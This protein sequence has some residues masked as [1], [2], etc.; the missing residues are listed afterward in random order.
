MPVYQCYVPKGLLDHSVKAK[1]A[2]EITTIHTNATGAP[3]LYVNVLFHEIPDGDHFVARKPS[4]HS[5]LFGLIRHGRDLE[6][7]Q[8]MLRDFSRMWTR[9]TGQSEAELLVALSEADPANAMEAG[10]IL[11]EPGQE[12][13]WFGENAGRLAELGVTP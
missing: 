11:P 5:Y 8:T 12:R 7:R 10:L 9:V 13:E 3:E 1:L 2:D 4:T 6:T